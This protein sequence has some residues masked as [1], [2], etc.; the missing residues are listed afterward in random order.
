MCAV[1]LEVATNGREWLVGWPPGP[2]VACQKPKYEVGGL[3]ARQPL[4]AKTKRKNGG[5]RGPD[6]AQSRSGN[7]R[8]AVTSGSTLQYCVSVQ[9][10]DKCGGPRSTSFQGPSD[11]ESITD[12]FSL[13][14]HM[15]QQRV[16][17]LYSQHFISWE[18]ESRPL[19]FWSHLLV[20]NTGVSWAGGGSPISSQ[21][22]PAQ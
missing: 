1:V 21:S 11:D 13:A 10:S 15:S 14:V 19:L 18:R 6:G 2:L 4:P 9:C 12:L 16:L 17:V 20:A 5:G 3:P 22:E 7:D 8:P